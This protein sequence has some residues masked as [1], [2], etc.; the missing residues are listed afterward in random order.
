MIP[1]TE[2]VNCYS[3]LTRVPLAEFLMYLIIIPLCQMTA[4][5]AEQ[6]VD[7]YLR[8]EVISF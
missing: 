5:M 4:Q 3:G 6:L 8:G 1:H 2:Y 7:D